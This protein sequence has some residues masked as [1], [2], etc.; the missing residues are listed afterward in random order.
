[1]SSGLRINHAAD[2]AAGLS[3]SQ[4][5]EAQ[6]RGTSTAQ[7]NAQDAMSLLQTADGALDEVHTILQRIRELAVQGASDTLTS[8]D[9]AALNTEITALSTELNSIGSNVTFNTQV[10]L[11]GTFS[12]TF[13]VGPDSGMQLNVNLSTGIS[14]TLGGGG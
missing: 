2:D 8:N 1:L 9:R 11:N 13:Q 3:I 6:V 14:S 4:K 10:L 5:L 7:R 12:G